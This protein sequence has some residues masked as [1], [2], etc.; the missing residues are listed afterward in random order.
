MITLCQNNTLVNV[1]QKYLVSKILQSQKDNKYLWTH[2]Y[3]DTSDT[4]LC[5]Y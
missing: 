1:S 3:R 5:K 2:K 4:V